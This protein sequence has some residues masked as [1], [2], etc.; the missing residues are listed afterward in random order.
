M[1]NPVF[2]T[3]S[4]QRAALL[5]CLRA[6]NALTESYMA[7]LAEGAEQMRDQVSR[8]SEDWRKQPFVLPNGPYWTDLYGHRA[9][10]IDVEHDV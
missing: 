4:L 9:H 2:H 5:G 10:D 1:Y 3:L 6:T 7:L 8:R